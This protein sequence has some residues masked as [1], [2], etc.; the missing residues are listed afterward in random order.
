LQKI[1]ALNFS[2]NNYLLGDTKNGIHEFRAKFA[3]KKAYRDKVVF[4]SQAL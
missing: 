3:G 1:R 2:L 4:C